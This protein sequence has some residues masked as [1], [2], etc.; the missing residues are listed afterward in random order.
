MVF[1]SWDGVEPWDLA[2]RWRFCWEWRGG[3]LVVDESV[4]VVYW[5]WGL[6]FPFFVVSFLLF[7]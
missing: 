7:L 3:W 6:V 2:W 4:A 5:N 1:D